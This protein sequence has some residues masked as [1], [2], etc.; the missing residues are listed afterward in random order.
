M[1][2]ECLIFL[3]KTIECF[4]QFK[5]VF[6]IYQQLVQIVEHIDNKKQKLKLYIGIGNLCLS[7]R[8]FEE[9]VHFFKKC[10]E[11]SWLCNEKHLELKVYDKLGYSFYLLRDMK[12]AQYFHHKYGLKIFIFFLGA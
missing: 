5:L 9:A 11:L 4:G 3:C 7:L 2:L 8:Y 1:I 12:K 10:I 6:G